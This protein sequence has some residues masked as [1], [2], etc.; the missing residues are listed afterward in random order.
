MNLEEY[1]S[2][3]RAYVETKPGIGTLP[4]MRGIP[5]VIAALIAAGYETN[6]PPE[7]LDKFIRKYREINDVVRLLTLREIETNKISKISE[8]FESGC[9]YS[10]E[11]VPKIFKKEEIAKQYHDAIFPDTKSN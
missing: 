5:A 3:Y 9:I 7:Q 4:E 2:S 1:W 11:V 6:L 8:A 10:K